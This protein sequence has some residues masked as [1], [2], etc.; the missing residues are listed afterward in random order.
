MQEGFFN[1][2]GGQER[3]GVRRNA[4]INY[5]VFVDVFHPRIVTDFD[6]R[7]KLQRFNGGNTRQL[8][9]GCP[10][11]TAIFKSSMTA[12]SHC[13]ICCSTPRIMPDAHSES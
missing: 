13:R 8:S 11:P 10:C 3:R 9:F 1:L 7:L 12:A 4:G 6:S 2:S 5:T